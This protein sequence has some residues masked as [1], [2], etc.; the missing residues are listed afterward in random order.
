MKIRAKWESD[1]LAEM[2]TAFTETQDRKWLRQYAKPS[3][4]CIILK[5]MQRLKCKKVAHRPHAKRT[6]EERRILNKALYR[7]CKIVERAIKKGA[8]PSPRGLICVDCGGIASDYEHRDYAKPLEVV[9]VCRSCNAK[10]GPAILSASVPE[11]KFYGRKKG[12]CYSSQRK[13]FP[14]DKSL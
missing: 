4:L 10:R 9:P 6:V 7:A 13:T 5:A 14:L 2:G 1:W 8:L 11:R 3:K 12:P